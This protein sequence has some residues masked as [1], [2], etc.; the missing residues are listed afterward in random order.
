MNE[1]KTVKLSWWKRSLEGI[2]RESVQGRRGGPTRNFS[3]WENSVILSQNLHIWRKNSR[4]DFKNSWKFL[5]FGL[6]LHQIVYFSFFFLMSRK[7]NATCFMVIRTFPGRVYRA[8]H[9][10]VSSPCMGAASTYTSEGLQL[11]EEWSGKII[12]DLSWLLTRSITN[13][14]RSFLEIF[15]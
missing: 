3:M 4:R 6:D 10:T 11:K 2:W 14:N 9:S 13:E 7:K 1:N 8:S 12:N 5:S 15:A